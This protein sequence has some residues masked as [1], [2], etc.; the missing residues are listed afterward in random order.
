MTWGTEAERQGEG[1]VGNEEGWWLLGWQA[2][3]K[4]GKVCVYALLLLYIDLQ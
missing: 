3:R 1:Q 2:G 4:G